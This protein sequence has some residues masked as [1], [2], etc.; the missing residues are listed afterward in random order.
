MNSHSPRENF[1]CSPLVLAFLSL[2]EVLFHDGSLEELYV[3]DST[4]VLGLV[5]DP[6]WA[7]IPEIG[8]T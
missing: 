2:R 7:D 4:Q 5:S 8:L 1:P 3:K 6:P